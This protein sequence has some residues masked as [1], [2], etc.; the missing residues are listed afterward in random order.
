MPKDVVRVELKGP[1]GVDITP[2]GGGQSDFELMLLEQLADRWSG[3]QAT[4][5][6]CVWFEIDRV[7]QA[8]PVAESLTVPVSLR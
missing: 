2:R 8:T 1:A 3:E 7:P 4:D 6:G 5:G